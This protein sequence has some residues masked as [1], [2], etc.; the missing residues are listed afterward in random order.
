MLLDEFASPVNVHGVKRIIKSFSHYSFGITC[1][2]SFLSGTSGVPT[3]EE[4]MSKVCNIKERMC[5]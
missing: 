3:I 5:V 1:I 4:W 2:L